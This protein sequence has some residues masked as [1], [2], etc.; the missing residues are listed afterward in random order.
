MFAFEDVEKIDKMVYYE[1]YVHLM[2]ILH[3]DM[4]NSLTDTEFII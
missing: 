2:G 1:Y 3:I 4:Y